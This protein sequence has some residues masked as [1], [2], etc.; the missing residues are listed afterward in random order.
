M[1]SYGKR[2]FVIASFIPTLYPEDPHIFTARIL[3]GNL[4]E[5]RG[6][7][8]YNGR[9]RGNRVDDEESNE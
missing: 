8:R 5:K 2:V 3:P 6:R 7:F 9:E 4:K 1:D